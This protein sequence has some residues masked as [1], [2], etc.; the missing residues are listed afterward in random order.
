[1]VHVAGLLFTDDGSLP[2]EHDGKTFISGDD[3]HP[4][5]I[6]RADAKFMG[7]DGKAH[8]WE[9]DGRDLRLKKRE[10]RD[11]WLFVRNAMHKHGEETVLA[12]FSR[13]LRTLKQNFA[14]N[15]MS[16]EEKRQDKLRRQQAAKN[17][18]K[19]AEGILKT[20]RDKIGPESRQAILACMLERVLPNETV[21][22]SYA[23]DKGELRFVYEQLLADDCLE[24]GLRILETADLADEI[25]QKVLHKMG[26][27][28]KALQKGAKMRALS[29]E[30]AQKQYEA[31]LAEQEAQNGKGAMVER[32]DQFCKDAENRINQVQDGLCKA[33]LIVPATK[34]MTAADL[35]SEVVMDSKDIPHSCYDV[36]EKANK[37]DDAFFIMRGVASH[38]GA[39]KALSETFSQE[40]EKRK[41]A[42][43]KRENLVKD[44]PKATTRTIKVDVQD[45][46]TPSSKRGKGTSAQDVAVKKAQLCMSTWPELMRDAF[47]TETAELVCSKFDG[48]P[49]TFVGRDG[50]EHPVADTEIGFWDQ[51]DEYRAGWDTVQHAVQEYGALAVLEP[52]AEELGVLDR[53]YLNRDARTRNMQQKAPHAKSTQHSAETEAKA[54]L[55]TMGE[56]MGGESRTAVLAGIMERLSPGDF[57]FLSYADADG[58]LCFVYEQLQQDECLQEAMQIIEKAQG[59]DEI[60]Q[61]LLSKNDKA[62]KALN[63][64]RGMRVLRILSYGEQYDQAT[65]DYKQIKGKSGDAD[66]IIEEAVSMIDAIQNRVYRAALIQF[67]SDPPNPN[68]LFDKFV[69]DSWNHPCSCYDALDD[70]KKLEQAVQLASRAGYYALNSAR[71][72]K[73]YSA[74][75]KAINKQKEKRDADIAN[76][77]K[78]LGFKHNKTVKPAR[79]WRSTKTEIPI[80]LVPAETK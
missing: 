14:K 61:S 39:A 70:E 1:M 13:E 75:I 15:N 62:C 55:K 76:T 48:T 50:Q 78:E 56:K 40:K 34:E 32:E 66:E 25:G 22:H 79:P 52:F 57:L 33:A 58:K 4:G 43:K 7:T 10:W 24:E 49:N 69:F 60:A 12:P 35:F 51:K 80:K 65:K 54:I 30:A 59:S 27:T 11:E 77:L 63:Q 31:Y 67:A 18:A 68:D 53:L 46:K 29:K 9:R 26:K 20:M 42:L 3:P 36:L 2:Y 19:E 45:P 72:E 47:L 74:E 41:K 37:L 23:N 44:A 64:G 5:T 17:A 8:L 21:L 73:H 38:K 6:V 16:P 28:C 71:I